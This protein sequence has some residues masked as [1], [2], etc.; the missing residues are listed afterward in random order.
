MAQKKI[1]VQDYQINVGDS[2]SELASICG[3][4][5]PTRIFV[6]V[7]EM[8]EKFCLPHLQDKV[9]ISFDS[10][11][12]IP[13]GEKNKTLPTCEKIWRR[14]F[15]LNADRKS[16]L[17]N[18]G[19]GVI[20]DMGGFCASTY[21]RGIPFVQVPTTL[22]SQVDASIG[23]K[24]GIDYYELKNSIGLFCNPVS[25]LIDPTFLETL[26]PREVRSGYAEI[27]K[28]GLIYDRK[29][30]EICTQITDLKSA[31][32]KELIVQSLLVKKEIVD[33]D[34]REKGLR[35]IL[36]FGHTI[37]HA[38]ESV[39]MEDDRPLL[40]GEA[41]AVGMLAEGYLSSIKNSFSVEELQLLTEYIL[42]IYGRK[43]IGTEL[44]NN[45]FNKMLH[46]K[47]NENQEINFSL[48]KKIG[49]AE[50]NQTADKE[51]IRESLSFYSNL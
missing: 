2:L 47:K 35:K 4:L 23:G 18:L 1:N 10:I 14:L 5:E 7:D 45:M 28:H 50:I 21:M 49:K 40:H 48:L 19:G 12:T 33:H 9:D 25:V 13:S 24:L 27:I 32:W 20:G 44:Y 8:T 6:L 41:I 29:L 39:M 26:S 17:I 3:R 37:G 31:D 34:P 22:L 51:Q 46:D 15:N 11:I 38:V 42:E 43:E 16:L 30:W 36:N